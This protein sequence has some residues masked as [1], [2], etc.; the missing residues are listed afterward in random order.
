V[1]PRPREPRPEDSSYY[2]WRTD[3]FR[4][5]DLFTEIPLG[6]PFPPNAVDHKEGT[7]KFLSGPFEPGFGL[8]LSPSCSIAAQGAVGQ[9]AHPHRVV[10]PILS[11]ERLVEEEAIK[12]GAVDELRRSDHLVNYLYLPPIPAAK[13]PESLALLYAPIT[14]HHDY[15]LDRRIAQLS[16]SA[17]IHLKRQLA[18]HF[19]G[20]LFS[21]AAF[22]D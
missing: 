9:Y 16:R 5:G 17:A 6:Q 4:Q 20:A 1:S 2:E 19:G 8:L 21:H 11:L 13:M 10:A 7:R 22:D 14:L 15:L 3:Y 12:A 18:L